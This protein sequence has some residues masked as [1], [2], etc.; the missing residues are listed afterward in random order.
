M[1]MLDTEHFR[2]ADLIA[3]LKLI[4]AHA[5]PDFGVVVEVHGDVVAFFGPHDGEIIAASAKAMKMAKP[6]PPPPS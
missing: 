1:T 2:V 3:A 5:G 4:E 6:L